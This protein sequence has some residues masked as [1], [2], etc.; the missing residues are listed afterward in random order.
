[1]TLPS[2]V[3]I[4][5]SCYYVVQWQVE[6]YFQYYATDLI[7]SLI[8]LLNKTFLSTF[9]DTFLL[10]IIFNIILKYFYLLFITIIKVTFDNM[11]R[12]Y[13]VVNQE[14]VDRYQGKRCT[15]KKDSTLLIVRIPCT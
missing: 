4:T 15:K 10:R 13:W 5:V 7:L 9:L 14:K 1:M 8:K 6:L 3:N 2:L 12:I 11:L